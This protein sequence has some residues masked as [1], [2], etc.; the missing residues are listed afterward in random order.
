M[1]PTKKQNIWNGHELLFLQVFLLYFI[2]R[3]L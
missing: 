1:E 3:I 2:L